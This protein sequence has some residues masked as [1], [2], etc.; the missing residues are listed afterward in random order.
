M[1]YCS[2]MMW[3]L[4]LPSTVGAD[5]IRIML[6]R[7]FG[8]RVDDALATI[9]VE[10]G[11]GFVSALLM[12]V[13]EPAAAAGSCVP[14][15]AEYDIPLLLGIASLL[16]GDRRAA[17]FLQQQGAS[18]SMLA[19]A[20]AARRAELGRAA[21]LTRLHEAYRS[22]ALDRAQAGAVLRADV[23]EQLLMAVCYGLVALALQLE[24]NVVFLLAAVPLAILVS[25]L[26]ISI[27]GLGVYEGIFIGIMSLGGV[28]P[29]DSLAM[30]LAARAFQIMVWMPWWLM[31]VARTGALRPPSTRSHPSR[32]PA[33]DRA[34]AAGC[35]ALIGLTAAAV[36]GQLL[37]GVRV[38]VVRASLRSAERFSTT[39]SRFISASTSLAL[40]SELR[41]VVPSATTSS[42]PSI[43]GANASTSSAA[44]TGGMSKIRMR[45]G[46]SASS[47]CI[48][49][50][51]RGEVSSSEAFSI[52]WKFGITASRSMSGAVHDALEARVAQQVVAQALLAGHVAHAQ[53]VGDARPLQVEVDQD[54]QVFTSCASAIARLTAVSVLPS[55]AVTPVTANECHWFA[56]RRRSTR[57]RRI[58]YARSAPASCELRQDEVVV[59]RRLVQRDRL[60]A[61]RVRSVDR[62]RRHA[63]QTRL[64]VAADRREDCRL[65]RSAFLRTASSMML[66]SCSRPRQ[67]SVRARQ[68][69]PRRIFAMPGCARV[70]R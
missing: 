32:R 70:A 39:P 23:A 14:D 61:L 57:V 30:S 25:R 27:D 48:S 3:G 41:S 4:A 29:D 10:R 52:G 20:A 18:R 68:N 55:P 19:P 58:L 64:A 35:Y 42:R 53:V 40:R 37:L 62:R 66:M 5:G 21:V 43:C 46:V 16:V 36:G 22:L 12:A 56:S 13:H 6:V 11:I 60:E 2:A 15:A 34:A 38:R 1:V 24:F 51:M 31:L 7:R 33:S 54:T 45:R 8:V 17:A 65:C 50:A 28:R 49:S 44:S 9:L 47:A 26:P 67:L 59:Q 63:A 69:G